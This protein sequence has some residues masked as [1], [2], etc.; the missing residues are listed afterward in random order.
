VFPRLDALARTPAEYAKPV[1]VVNV[2]DPVPIVKEDV[3]V[4]VYPGPVAPVDPVGP[5]C[6]VPQTIVTFDVRVAVVITT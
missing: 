6:P 3:E 1:C 2:V 5:I 4:A